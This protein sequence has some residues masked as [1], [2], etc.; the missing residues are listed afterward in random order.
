MKRWTFD[1]NTIILPN[2]LKVITIKK[3]TRLASINIGVNI[4]SLYEDEKEL[5]MS[6]FVEHMLFKG[7]K[8]RSNEQLNRELE[9]LG[10][11][12]NA[13]TDYISTVY[14]ITCLDEEF[15][16]GIEL[17]SDMVLNSSFDEKEM[18]KEKGVVLSEIK[19]DK[20]DIEDLSI[21]RTH[22][23]AFDKSAL[24]NSIAGTEEHVKG[25]KR[26]QVYDFYKKYY[27]PDNCVIVTVSAFSHEQMQKIITDLFGKWEGKS[28]KKAK[29]IK[30]ENKDIVK[31]TYK[32]Q[33]EQGTIT[34][35][36]AFKEVCEK[37]KLPLKILSYKL[38]ESSNSILFRELREERGLAYDVY[39]Q[40]DLDENVNTMNIFTSVREESIDEVIEVIDK[41]ILDI[42]NKDINF[43]EDML[44]MMKKTHKTGVVSTLED[45]SSLC[46]YVLVQSLAG[47]D[48]TEFIN[49]ME[50][51][52]TLT[53]EDI[54][55]V[56]NKYLNKPTIHILKPM[57]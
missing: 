27:T 15:E 40:M 25:F 2:G 7:T 44:C 9:F 55:R 3:D 22:E 48:I 6:H 29:I 52:E 1:E 17:L 46:S 5:G 42:K 56:C 13:Y 41:A 53:G 26:K 39:S 10:G 36:Y 24:R 4:G 50:E 32:S 20:D 35:L 57:E 49:S 33:I 31:T 37:D 34:Y 43:D 12:Y 11:D 18:K 16:K 45:C 8:N 38:A 19:S 14:S 47:K 28:H 54:Y 21:S 51:L 30:E 23:Y